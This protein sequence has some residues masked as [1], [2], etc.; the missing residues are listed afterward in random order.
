MIKNECKE[1]KYFYLGTVCFLA[2]YLIM[3][4]WGNN[5]L[6]AD[7]VYYFSNIIEARNFWII[8]PGVE[9]FEKL[10]QLFCVIGIKLGVINIKVLNY[11]YSFGCLYLQIVFTILSMNLCIKNKKYN[12]FYL[13]ILCI[14]LQIIFTGFFVMMGYISYAMICTYSFL[15]LLFYNNKNSELSKICFCIFMALLFFRSNSLFL[16]LG[17]MMILLV[18]YKLLIK[19]ERIDWFYFTNIIIFISGCLFALNIIIN[20]RDSSNKAGYINSIMNLDKTVYIFFSLLF[21]AVLFS[22]IGAIL[23]KYNY[24][25]NGWFDYLSIIFQIIAGLV[26]LYYICRNI[27]L[28]AVSSYIFRGLNLIITFSVFFYIL[29]LEA[30][31]I[32]LSEH[33][34]KYCN[35]LFLITGIIF[36]FVSTN[37]YNYHLKYIDDRLS[38]NVGYVEIN[39]IETLENNYF[40]GWSNSLE[41]LYAQVINDRLSIKSV[42]INGENYSGWEPFD[43]RNIKLYPDLQYYGVNYDN[44]SFEY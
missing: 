2:I 34:Y 16:F 7:G 4:I 10:R 13:I 30:F 11:L 37:N 20:P 36:I 38:N 28:V 9:L 44:N 15:Y 42:I 23:Q 17:A 24:K 3:N 14:S 31:N 43:S 40:W 12:Y 19:K 5:S 35:A 25:F 39:E 26:L 6:Y 33:I 29:F 18:I 21:L 1:I 22:M 27:H 41:S 8:E 32:N